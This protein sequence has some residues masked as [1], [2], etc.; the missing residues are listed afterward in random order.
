MVRLFLDIETLPCEE[1]KKEIYVKILHA[2]KKT[3]VEIT[4]E[5]RE[6]I[7]KETSLEGTFGR[8]CCI[9]YMKEEGTLTKEAISGT[10]KEILIRFWEI[11]KNVT[12]FVGHNIM[13]F[14]LPFIYKRSIIHGIKPSQNI[15]FVRYRSFP[16]FD[17]QKEWDKWGYGKAQKLDTLA[18]VLGFPT[19]KDEMDGSQVW[20]FYQQG[21]LDEICTYCMKDVELTRK[22]FYKMN[23]EEIMV[24][25]EDWVLKI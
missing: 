13:E 3:G 5:M 1:E 21:K 11:A 10:E 2:K 24:K 12:Q 25:N 7:H 17:T 22:V 14:D 15:S 19:S 9:G 8:I 23:F 16:I 20:D 6:E 4:E 18:K